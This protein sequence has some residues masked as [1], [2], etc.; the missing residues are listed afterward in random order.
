MTEVTERLIDLQPAFS[1]WSVSKIKT[2]QKCPLQFYLKYVIKLKVKP[3]E[4]TPG[5]ILTMTGKDAHKV[6]ELSLGG[7]PLE[8]ALNRVKDDSELPVEHWCNVENLGFNIQSFVDRINNFKAAHKIKRIYQELQIGITEDLKPTS[9][10]GTNVWFRGIIDFALLMENGDLIPVDHKTGP[11]PSFGLKNY[12]FQ[13]ESY[14]PLFHYGVTPINNGQYGVHFIRAGELLTGSLIPREDIETRIV[15]QLHFNIDTA[16]DAIKDAGKFNY[17][18]GSQ[19]EYCDYRELCRGGK[20]GTANQLQHYIE[21]TKP[22]VDTWVINLE[23]K[24]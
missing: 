21:K 5:D 13:L 8:K 4:V 2:L 11:D 10:Y 15:N 14:L 23:K 9:F 22:I 12:T 24:Q 6:L 18:I 20:R 19:C 16:V 3:T 7:M 17:K 1:A